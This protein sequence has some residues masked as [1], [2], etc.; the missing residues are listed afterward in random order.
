MTDTDGQILRDLV[1]A[2]L[3]AD[4]FSGTTYFMAIDLDN[5]GGNP[6]SAGAGPYKHDDSGAIN[7]TSVHAFAAKNI[8][9]NVWDLLLG[10]ILAIDNTEATIGFTKLGSMHLRNTGTVAVVEIINLYP[11]K[12]HLGVSGGNFTR[13]ADTVGLRETT[14][15]VNALTT[16]NDVGGNAVIPAVGDIV[17]KA[18]Q[19]S[20]NSDLL[21]HY[22]ISYNADASA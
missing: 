5:R 16:M 3:F 10:T 22:L 14:T 13:I 20:G 15:D 6:G 8:A 11:N 1:V 7:I 19:T 21:L 9:G 2:D 18:D 12:L 17:I 4:G